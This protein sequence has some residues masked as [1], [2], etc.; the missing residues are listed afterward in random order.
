MDHDAD[1]H[2]LRNSELQTALELLGESQEN[3][4][5]LE[6]TQ[7]VLQRRMALQTI[8]LLV[9]ALVAIISVASARPD[10]TTSID[11][12]APIMAVAA[13]SERDRLLQG[14][15]PAERMRVETFEAQVKWL[16]EY[17][18]AS[19]DFNAGAAIALFISNMANDM[20]AV[21]QMHQEMLTMSTRMAALPAMVLEMQAINAKLAV[22]ATAMDSTM[23]RTGRMLPW[24]PFAP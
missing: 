2:T 9:A 18:S 21:P 19:P 5:R 13:L 1:R 14:L 4:R 3:C 10:T 16:S 23:G 17:M 22:I 6:A 7:Q 20:A 12:E 11:A 15:P 8:A 24:M